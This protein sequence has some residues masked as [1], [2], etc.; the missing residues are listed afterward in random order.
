VPSAL[1]LEL[2]LTCPPVL[3]PSNDCTGKGNLT[4]FRFGLPAGSH[5]FRGEWWASGEISIVREATIEF[6]G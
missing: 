3:P 6:V 1:D 4:N 5:A 2:N